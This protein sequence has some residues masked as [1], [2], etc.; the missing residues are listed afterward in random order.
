MWFDNWSDMLRV[1][2]VGAAAYVWVVLVL[3]VTG[4][5][6]LAKLNAFDLVVTVAL[7][8]TLATILLSADV[9]FAEGALAVALLAGLQ[10]A[11]AAVTSWLPNGRSFVTARP[12]LLLLDGEPRPDALRDQRVTEAELRQ[13]VRASGTGD[14]SKVAAVVLESDGTMSVISRGKEGS[15]SAAPDVAGLPSDRTPPER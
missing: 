8:S 3:R 13:A 4:K 14:L 7:G 12:T 5:R 6:T 1:L 11:V 10:M 2:L 9:S 15:W